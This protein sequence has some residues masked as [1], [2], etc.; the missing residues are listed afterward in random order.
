MG[1]RAAER[2]QYTGYLLRIEFRGLGRG[3]IGRDQDSGSGRRRR[4]AAEHGPQHLVAD[5]VDVFGP[6]PQVRIRHRGELRGELLHGRRPRR[7]R[8]HASVDAFPHGGEQLVVVEQQLVSVEYRRLRLT[9]LPGGPI[10]QLADGA[11]HPGDG[12]AQATPFRRGFLGGHVGNFDRAQPR[13]AGGADPK[14]GS[15]ADR[16]LRHSGFRDGSGGRQRLVEVTRGKGEHVVQRLGGLTARHPHLDLVTAADSQRG[17]L[18]QAAGVDPRRVAAAVADPRAGVAAA[19]L[20]HQPRGGPGVQA[21]RVGDDER[22]GQL[23]GVAGLVGDLRDGSG[24]EVPDLSGQCSGRP[25][26]PP[27]RSMLRPP[28]RP[29]RRPVPPPGERGTIGPG[30]GRRRRAVRRPVRPRARRYR[31]PSAPRPR[32]PG[33]RR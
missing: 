9:D 27:R 4:R 6:G 11:A 8:G 19:H 32:G 30:R 21:V 29:P 15:R 33:R 26:R 10:A 25:R 23:V 3:Q 14:A 12:L 17:Q 16:G 2:Q 13:R 31:G 1:V 7:R 5:G 28:R 22:A 18:R 20:L 24:A